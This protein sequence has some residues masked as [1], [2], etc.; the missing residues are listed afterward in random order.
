MFRK[1]FAAVIMRIREPKTTALIFASGKMVV[2]GAK[3]E[4]D[5]KLASRKYAR[6]IQKVE[7][8]GQNIVGSC[9][10]KFPIRA[11]LLPPPLQLVRTRVVPWPYLSHG[12]AQD[13]PADFCFWQ[14]R[15]DRRQGP[16][17][18]LPGVPSHLPRAHRVP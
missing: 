3:S 11:C 10:V 4:D 14:D 18:D 7:V 8:P 5:S 16:R 15:A 2:T 1:R 13:R 12:Q 17:G 9:D 6:I